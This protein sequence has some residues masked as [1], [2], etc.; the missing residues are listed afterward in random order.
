MIN[1]AEKIDCRAFVSE[2]NF[3]H[4]SE[5]TFSA[6]SIVMPDPNPAYDNPSPLKA[7]FYST[8]IDIA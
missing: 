7:L 6:E 3:R 1:Y 8:L 2:K 4:F 5:K